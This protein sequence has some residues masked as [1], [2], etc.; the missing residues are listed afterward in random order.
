[1]KRLFTFFVYLSC[2]LFT[3]QAQTKWFVTSSALVTGSGNSWAAP[4]EL[5]TA[6]NNAS[7]GD[8]IFVAQGI[9]QRATGQSYSMKAGV[10]I[11]GGFAGTETFLSERNLKAPYISTLKGN[12]GRVVTNNNNGLSATAVLDGFTISN[13]TST[14]G[15][16][17]GNL[18]SSPTI[19]NCIFTANN[20]SAIYNT[21]NA[22]TIINC[23]FTGNTSTT[24]NAR[25]GGISNY[26]S[27]GVT[28]VNCLFWNNTGFS[29]GA[30]SVQD[31]SV[32]NSTTKIFNCTMYGN[33]ATASSSAAGLE[34]DAATQSQV[35]NCILWGNTITGATAVGM[36][37]Y[38]APDY[39]YINLVNNNII[40][41]GYP[42]NWDFDPHFVN[43]SNPIGPDNIWGTAD[44]GLRLQPNSLA[45]NNGTPDITSS[46]ILTFDI[47]GDTRVQGGRIDMG[48]YESTFSCNAPNTLYVDAGVAASGD[49]S[50]WSTAFK[51]FNEATVAANQCTNVRSILVAQGTYQAPAGSMYSMLPQV[52][53]Y[54]GFPTGGATFAQRNPILYTTILKGNGNRVFFNYNTALDTMALLDG[55]TI[56]GGTG[57]VAAANGFGTGILN[58]NTSPTI[59]NCIISGNTALS[60]GGA[61][62]G[63][64]NS[65]GSNPVISNCIFSDNTAS[66]NSSGGGGAMWNTNCAPTISHCVFI[67]N[68]TS[69]GGAIYNTGSAIPTI[70]N[71]VF[72]GNSA[73]GDGGAIESISNVLRLTNVTFINNIA[74]GGGGAIDNW[75][76]ALTITN[77]IFWGNTANANND[78]WQE[79][80][81]FSINYSF[82]QNNW[83]GT[84]NIQGSSS[85]FANVNTPA[86]A[87]GIWR[88]A[89]DGINLLV[90]SPCLN[91][92]IPDTTGLNLGNTDITGNAR[93]IG[94]TIDIGAYEYDNTALPI[95]LINFTGN[96][97]NNIASLQWNTAEELNFKYFAVEKSIDGA[98]FR[99]L[100]KVAAKGSGST[101]TYTTLQQEPL[102]YYRLKMVDIDGSTTNSQIIRLSQKAGN[103][104]LV[105]PN[106]ATNNINMQVHNAG[107]MRLYTASGQLVMTL[108]MQAGINKVDI[109]KL[110]T[111]VYYGLING[112]SMKIIIK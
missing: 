11:Y 50:S 52:K 100:G 49:G 93:I 38:A 19:S 8:S 46:P 90:G 48:V 91:A 7:A 28:I 22:A 78:I 85:P 84:G 104:I 92:G 70:T 3:L 97:A 60:N 13:G 14:T 9:Y 77:A 39:Q 54:G 29:A 112:Q 5:Q 65:Q 107:S 45:W 62:G 44:D 88:T 98:V 16:G 102:A 82:T 72:A 56:T 69:Y 35:K 108:Q 42:A 20:G 103:D 10:M 6:I 110:Q 53:T 106:P 76:C 57:S 68:R 23:I 95:T 37:K 25:A 87:D 58:L 99:A 15:G 21:G 32:F 89:D 66:T 75:N 61:G 59:N 73:S 12:N 31:N 4:L 34:F 41:Q 80:G 36:T 43:P 105:Y 1:M 30:I 74:G 101:Y 18:S 83:T 67:N 55:F 64:Y 40:Q 2:T 81:P 24:F 63:M 96:L 33:K 79:S 17:I 86:G 111:G 94:S 47:S 27:N 109:S 71:S 26:N 51:T